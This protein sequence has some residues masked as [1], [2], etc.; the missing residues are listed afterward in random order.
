[1]PLGYA[2]IFTYSPAEEGNGNLRRLF[3]CNGWDGLGTDTFVLKGNLILG[4]DVVLSDI[5][6]GLWG[7]EICPEKDKDFVRVL[8]N[9]LSGTYSILV[10]QRSKN[11]VVLWYKREPG[12][13]WQSLQKK[14]IEAEVAIP[15]MKFNGT[16]KIW[17]GTGWS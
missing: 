11:N 16:K 10:E 7:I 15:I 6:L 5:S 4:Y 14:L 3:V 12:S 13:C 1:M 2:Q 8:D 17:T 9:L